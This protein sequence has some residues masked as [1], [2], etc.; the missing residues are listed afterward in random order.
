[1]RSAALATV[2]LLTLPDPSAAAQE[3]VSHRSGALA[4]TLPAGW[5]APGKYI[6]M[7]DLPTGLKSQRILSFAASGAG[8][9]SS[10]A[11]D[12]DLANGGSFRIL[13]DRQ[14]DRV[15]FGSYQ[16]VTS[17]DVGDAPLPHLVVWIGKPQKGVL[18]QTY[19]RVPGRT[20]RLSVRCGQDQWEQV[21][22][23][24][25]AMTRGLKSKLPPFPTQPRGRT[26]KTADGVVFSS[27]KQVK[28]TDVREVQRCALDAQ[29]AFIEVHGAIERPKAEPLRI[30]VNE[31]MADH[32]IIAE[33][34]VVEPVV[35]EPGLHWM[36]T[37]ALDPRGSE[38]R[39][40]FVQAVVDQLLVEQYG[41]IEATW[42][43]IGER[44]V[45]AER[46]ATRRKLPSVRKSTLESLTVAMKFA[47]LTTHKKAPAP[48][49]YGQCLAYVATFHAGPKPYQEAYQAFLK[50]L[51]ATGDPE[52]AASQHLLALDQDQLRED[53]R[54][55]VKRLRPVRVRSR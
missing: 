7:Q 36:F 22:P 44:M 54:A 34:Q 43:V 11:V 2:V 17:V 47:E 40:R 37:V 5:R 6:K 45:A 4:I 39:N 51:R 14:R 52:Q 29:K 33:S 42:F 55:F 48:D 27:T 53:V 50:A 25:F 23:V 28:K 49:F 46:D 10:V 38:Q 20:I 13:P 15:F 8:L 12:V 31:L 26:E 19:T 16:G 35:S 32:K 3:V 41:M 30:F 18:A 9:K 24:L 21:K 1:M